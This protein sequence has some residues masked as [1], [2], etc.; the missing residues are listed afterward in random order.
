MW[1]WDGGFK[2]IWAVKYGKGDVDHGHEGDSGDELN[3]DLN[4]PFFGRKSLTCLS[5]TLLLGILTL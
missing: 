3:P 5:V 1:I 2:Y 4:A